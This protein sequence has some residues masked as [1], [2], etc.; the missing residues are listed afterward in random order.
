M[1]FKIMPVHAVVAL[2]GPWR[3]PREPQEGPRWPQEGPRWPQDGPK[4]APRRPKTAPR[5]PQ[6]APRR[7]KTGP[8]RPQ[9]AQDARRFP[10]DGT[11]ER[12]MALPV[13]C[14]DRFLPEVVFD[15]LFIGFHAPGGPRR[16]SYVQLGADT[17][18]TPGLG[19]S[20]APLG[21]L[22]GPSR[23]PLAASR[24]TGSAPAARELYL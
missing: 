15:P 11:P 18:K 16:P 23:R 1:N 9:M 21:A 17:P 20:W 12:E 24:M 8:G 3:A 14:P 7:T 13:P 19:A 6:D 4:T 5:R 2:E 10:R 22:S